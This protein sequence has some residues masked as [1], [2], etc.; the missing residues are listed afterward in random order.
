MDGRMPLRVGSSGDLVSW[1][2]SDARLVPVASVALDEKAERV[3]LTPE[4]A[5]TR[6]HYVLSVNYQGVLNDKLCGFYRSKYMIDGVQMVRSPPIYLC[7]QLYL[8]VCLSHI[9]RPM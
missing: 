6:G 4:R 1:S 9:G 8:S 3:C 5:L 7:V 2:R